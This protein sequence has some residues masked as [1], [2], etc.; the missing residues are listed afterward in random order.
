MQQLVGERLT[1][2]ANTGDDIEV[3]GGHVSPDPTLPYWL[4]DRIDERGW[5]LRDDSSSSW[6]CLRSSVRTCGSGL[7]TATSRSAFSGRDG[8][9][10]VTR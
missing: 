1:V 10:R 2:I 4:A 6:R 7:A 8:S 3:H 9:L 5:G